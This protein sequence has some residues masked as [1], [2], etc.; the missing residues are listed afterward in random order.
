M[1]GILYF[2]RFICNLNK[3]TKIIVNHNEDKSVSNIVNTLLASLV[4]RPSSLAPIFDPLQCARERRSERSYHM[5]DVSINLRRQTDGGWGPN[6]LEAFREVSVE[7]R[8]FVKL[9]TLPLIVQYK[10]YN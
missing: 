5:N 4:T 8:M 6:D 10:A 1:S 9:K 7:S 2:T 3:Q